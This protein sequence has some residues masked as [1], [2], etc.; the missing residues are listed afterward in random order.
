MYQILLDED[1]NFPGFDV[2]SGYVVYFLR[3]VCERIHSAVDIV[4]LWCVVG[5]REAC[6]AMFMSCFPHSE[7]LTIQFDLQ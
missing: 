2:D 5:A 7:Y 4:F 6:S 1:E 3:Y